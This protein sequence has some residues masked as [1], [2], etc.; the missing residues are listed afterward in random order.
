MANRVPPASKLRR[1]L[2]AIGLAA[3]IALAGCATPTPYQPL[4]AS[5][6]SARGGYSEAMLGPDHWRV[7]FA[8]N[9]LTS[10]ETVEGYLLYR[11]AELTLEQGNDWFRIVYRGLEHEVREEVRRD[12]LYRPWWGYDG[13]RPYWHYY[14]RPFGWRHWY[15]LDDDPFFDTRTVESFEAS[16]E[17]VMYEGQRPSGNGNVF[18]AREVIERLGPTVTRPE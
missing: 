1:R 6:S 15:P 18:D 11:A 7:N 2:A 5:S 14:D 16:A 17:I 13:W 4:G 3:A 10:R 8:G 12:P 9:M